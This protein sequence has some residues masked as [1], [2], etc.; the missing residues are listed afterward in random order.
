MPTPHRGLC[1]LGYTVAPDKEMDAPRIER[2][3]SGLVEALQ[4]VAADAEAQLNALPDGVHKPDEVA[5]LYDDAFL[6]ADQVL[7]ARRISQD[8]YGKLREIDQIFSDMSDRGP[9]LWTPEMMREAPEWEIARIRAREALVLLREP[10]KR[11]DPWWITYKVKPAGFRGRI[12]WFLRTK[13]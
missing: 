4:L 12:R 1:Q 9:D 5:L 7:R 6:L 2:F 8:Q 3:Y 13:R 11:P 10:V